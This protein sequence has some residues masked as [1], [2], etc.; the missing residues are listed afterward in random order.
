M[1]LGPGLSYVPRQRYL[2]LPKPCVRFNG[3]EYAK[4]SPTGIIFHDWIQSPHPPPPKKIK[5]LNFTWF[6]V[7]FRNI[8]LES[9]PPGNKIKV[10][11]HLPREFCFGSAHVI[12]PLT[13]SLSVLIINHDSCQFFP[14]PA[15]LN[16]SSVRQM[17]VTS[18]YQL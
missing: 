7:K 11:F 15:L 9:P 18:I 12:T 10:Y 16:I 1:I 14:L 6:I 8:G 3:P 2:N 17:M 4:L 5:L 13:K